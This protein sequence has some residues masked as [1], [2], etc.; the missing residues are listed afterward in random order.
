MS[1]WLFVIAIAAGFAWTIPFYYVGKS[2]GFRMA[3]ERFFPQYREEVLADARK[4]LYQ[5]FP[6]LKGENPDGDH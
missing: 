5:H 4:I 6:E 1:D 2:A 3:Q